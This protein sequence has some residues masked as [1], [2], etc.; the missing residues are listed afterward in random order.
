M[1]DAHLQYDHGCHIGGAPTSTAFC[2]YECHYY[3]HLSSPRDLLLPIV[4]RSD[5]VCCSEGYNIIVSPVWREYLRAN[6]QGHVSTVHHNKI[7]HRTERGRYSAFHKPLSNSSSSILFLRLKVPTKM[8]LPVMT[9]FSRSSP[10][11]TSLPANID[12]LRYIS[13]ALSHM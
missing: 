5:S 2:F 4:N 3:D 11:P 12:V 8:L 6:F 9:L 1:T 7:F 10:S 13:V